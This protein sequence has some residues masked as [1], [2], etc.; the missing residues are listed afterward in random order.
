MEKAAPGLG[1]AMSEHGW[2]VSFSIG[3][4][5]TDAPG[6]LEQMLEAADQARPA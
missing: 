2:N 3:V 6:S 4:V 5:A 1:E